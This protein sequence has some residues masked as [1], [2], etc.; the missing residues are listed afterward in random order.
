MS[1]IA[2][3]VTKSFPAMRSITSLPLVASL[4][5]PETVIPA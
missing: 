3:R 5:N 4:R 2:V 1:S